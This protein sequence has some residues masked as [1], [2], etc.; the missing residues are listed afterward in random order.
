MK[1]RKK[2]NIILKGLSEKLVQGVSI[3]LVS[4]VIGILTN[5]AQT[6]GIIKGL[7]KDNA[8]LEWAVDYFRK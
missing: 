8:D 6:H 3:A 7:E 5:Y 4:W 2:S 1:K